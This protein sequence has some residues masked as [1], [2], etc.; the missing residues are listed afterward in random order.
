[1]H[2]AEVNSGNADYRVLEGL[3]LK[4]SAGLC[5]VGVLVILIEAHNG[6]G[7]QEAAAG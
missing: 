2:A 4:S 1:V 3:E 5:A 7:L 6:C